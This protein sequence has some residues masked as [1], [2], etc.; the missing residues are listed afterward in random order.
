MSHTGA[1]PFLREE[2]HMRS[3][4]EIMTLILDTARADER[5][6]A[7]GMNG[8]R[9]NPDAPRDIFQDYDVVYFVTDMQS[10]LADH[11]WVDRFGKRL[12]M[13]MPE[14]MSL[15]PPELG[16]RFTYL[17]QF[18][19]GNRI[20]LMLAPVGDIEKYAQEDSLTK[21]LLDKDGR[22]PPLPPP[23]D[24]DYHVKRPDEACYQDCCCEFLWTACYVAKG[25]WRDEL[26]YAAYHLDRCV[27]EMLLLMLSWQVGTQTGFSVSTGK[28]GKYLKRYL[29]AETMDR[30]MRTYRCGS[31][32]EAW[33]ALYLCMELF[34]ESGS[35]T[36]E[37]L[38]CHFPAEQWERIMKYL[39]MV[40]KLPRDAKSF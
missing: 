29:P 23:S 27:R 33:A 40:E 4:Q 12:I 38:G 37:A 3:E 39:R 32:A 1:L 18:E 14:G 13:Q 22:F 11:S 9:T 15:F 31:E 28:C 2:N 10:F 17:M 19:D 30:L 36:A 26:L 35:R 8:S 16:G 34:R 7:V 20:D 6:R 25:L 24:R 21:I 5:I